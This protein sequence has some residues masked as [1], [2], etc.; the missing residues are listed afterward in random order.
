MRKELTTIHCPWLNMGLAHTVQGDSPNLR[1]SHTIA[2]CE[3]NT[4]INSP[5]IGMSLKK[6]VAVM[7]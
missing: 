5:N 2:E 6:H 1:T 4:R 7:V 3:L